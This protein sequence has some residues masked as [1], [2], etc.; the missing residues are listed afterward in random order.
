MRNVPNRLVRDEKPRILTSVTCLVMLVSALVIASPEARGFSVSSGGLASGGGLNLTEVAGKPQLA[1]KLGARVLRE[2]MTGPDVR[3]LKG[4][5]HSQ[6]LLVGTVVSDRF[7]PPTTK[8]VRR[9]QR[10]AR[11]ATSG[12]VNRGTAREMIG[13]LPTSGASWY[14]PGFYGS[15]TACGQ[16]LRPATQGVAHKTLPCGSKVLIGFRGR[17]VI[18]RVIDRG[19]FIGGRAWDLTGAVAK[20]LRFERVGVGDVRHALLSGR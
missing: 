14:G 15:R 11:F 3:V 6:S 8:A 20:A 10:K 7:D 13:S 19:P 1:P 16:I 17:F 9:F 18:T 12:V 2:G 4:I 5:V